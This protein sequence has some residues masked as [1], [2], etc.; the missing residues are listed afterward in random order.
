MSPADIAAAAGI[1]AAYFAGLVGMVW[2]LR[3]S[4]F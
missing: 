1:V 4:D 3:R 2:W